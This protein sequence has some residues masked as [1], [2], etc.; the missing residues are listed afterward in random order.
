[1]L[2]IGKLTPGRAEYY[3]EQV[4]AGQ[5]EYYLADQ[6]EPGHWTGRAAA[7]LGL[8][9]E[10][11]PEAFR[12]VLDARHP[13][14]G[15]TLGVPVTSA[16]RVAGFD[17]CFSAPKSIS[18]AWAFG[19]PEQARAIA[20][21][22]D[23]AVAQAVE[24]IEAE[25]LR[26]RRGA[27]GRDVITTEGLVGAAFAHRSSRLGEPQLHTHLVVA[28]M[29]PDAEGR[30]TAPYGGRLYAWAKTVGYLY[31][32]ALRDELSELGFGFGAV[33]KGAGELEGVPRAA[34]EAF[35][36]RRADIEAVLGEKGLSSRS[37]AQA[38][39]LATRRPK[40][41]VPGLSELRAQWREQGAALGLGPSFVAGLTT[42]RRELA[43]DARDLH[44]Q[45]LSEEGLTANA[46][47]FDRQAVLQALAEAHP[48][49]ATIASLRASAD[50]LARSPE[51]VALATPAHAEARYS[52]AELISVEAALLERAQSRRRA[53]LGLVAA[54][55][56]ASVLAARRSL[57]DEQRHMVS[58]LTSAGDGAQVVIGRAGAGK[59]FALDAARAAWEVSGHRVIGAALAA[60]A[61]AE[62]QAGAG[63][64]S[65]TIDRLLADLDRPGPLSGLVPGTVLVVDEA[66]MVGTRKLAR[67]FAHAEHW[68]AQ[69]VL[70]GDPRQLPE[71]A[72]GGAFSALAEG[73]PVIELKDNRRQHEAWERDA[74]SQLRSGSIG[75]AVAAYQKAGRITLAASAEAAREAMVEGWW[76]SRERGEDAM[77][78]ALRRSD[79]DDLNMRAR[80]RLD[81]AG[82]LGAERLVVAGRE[83][84]VGDRVMTLRN[85]RRLGTRNGTVATIAALDM[86]QAGATLSD[87]TQLSR[88]YLEAGHLAYAHASTVHKAQG[89]TVDRAFLLGSDQLYREAGY[90]GLSRAR[91]SNELFVVATEPDEAMDDLAGHLRTSRAQALAIRQLGTDDRDGNRD[92]GHALLA[93]PPLWASAA[94]GEPPLSGPDRRR[95]AERAAQLASYRDTHG[96]SDHADVLGRRPDEQL[97]RRAWDLTQLTLLEHQRSLEMDRGLAR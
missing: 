23:S 1:M 7:L 91:L 76:Q 39:A 20:G 46:S 25:V 52:T 36:S 70:I 12:R 17:L 44:A 57:S 75:D 35:S 58:T 10:V 88:S 13:A 16:G 53:G 3:V 33:K 87:G 34:I 77:M 83:L 48:G 67:L 81:G 19:A 90:V 42:H 43:P 55:V 97:E 94:L 5:D 61:A 86:A 47:S 71:V 79:V 74:L 40:A 49:G 50:A 31:Q 30:W 68:G 14:T 65:G 66:G 51:V 69:V 92:R 59:T 37:A 96:V 26:A 9:G 64:P 6:A 93:D 62:L 8:E 60:R 56:L 41:A 95:W 4:H 80:A 21:A 29:T 73:L 22:H 85:D 38:A 84:A 89:A 32:A 82:E 27:G 63:I 18:L 78:Y 2:S 54:D 15:E 11:T 28:N 45:L 24:A 72:A